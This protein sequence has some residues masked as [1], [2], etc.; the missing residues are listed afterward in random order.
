MYHS[1][2]TVA[3]YLQYLNEVVKVPRE[4]VAPTTHPAPIKP[5]R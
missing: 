2:L 4:H 3:M 1:T 5:K